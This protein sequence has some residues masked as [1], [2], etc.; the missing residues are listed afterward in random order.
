MRLKPRA[1]ETSAYQQA[2]CT[3]LQLKDRRVA[4]ELASLAT[5][6]T[7]CRNICTRKK[8]RGH[9]KKVEMTTS[10]SAVSSAK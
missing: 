9:S 6:V 10:S 2:S 7:S 3:D 4:R 1:E 5:P 8:K